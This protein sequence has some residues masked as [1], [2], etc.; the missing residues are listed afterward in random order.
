LETGDG[1]RA[2]REP[3]DAADPDGQGT[4]GG[5]C[6]DAGGEGV[7]LFEEILHALEK[8]GPAELPPP[9][10]FAA[11][12]PE[13]VRDDPADDAR[14]LDRRLRELVRIR[15]SVAWHEGRLLNTLARFGLY[16]DLGFPSLRRYCRE[17]IG[18][19]LRRARHLIALDRR[20]ADLPAVA[21]AYRTGALS[22]VR[23]A[24]VARVASEATEQA[25]IRLAAS[26]TVRRLR[27]EVALA[28]AAIDDPAPWE[29]RPE[30]ERRVDRRGFPPGMDAGGRVQTCAPS[31]GPNGMVPD[32]GVQTCAAAASGTVAAARTQVRFWAPL[33]VARLWRHALA[34]CRLVDAA[35]G[36]AGE[37]LED[38]ECVDRMIACFRQSMEVKG[39]AAWRRRYRVFERDGWR[40]RV[41][42]CS[43]RRNLHEHHV[44]FRSQGGGDGD[45]NLVAVCATHHLRVVHA[46]HAR[47]RRLPDGS[48]L[49]E[50][51]AGGA[52]PP[53]ARYIE[54]VLLEA[55]GPEARVPQAAA[56]A[57]G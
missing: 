48:L 55:A 38:W 53:L 46:G 35:E 54:D 13:S 52:D 57:A 14:A 47:C 41:P 32:G 21:E 33:D 10:P 26:V 56:R 19:S 50:L 17:R 36:G 22:W 51:G 16:R 20:L 34:V 1:E 28:E 44:V 7:E 42:G 23:A 11:R 30:R 4:A 8:D 2:D 3:A 43:S 5:G 49:W 40:C 27:D 24:S 37:A 12:L 6:D 25:W 15:Q 39:D 9:A 29:D 31:A 45:D 18:I